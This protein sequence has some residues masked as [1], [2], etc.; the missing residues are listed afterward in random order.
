MMIGNVFAQN[1]NMTD[2]IFSIR[3]VEVVG[4]NL[5]KNE[6]GKLNVP[7]QY[8]PLS[9]TTVSAN[10]LDMRGIVNMQDAVKFLPNTRMRTTYGAYQQFEVRGFDFTPIMIDGVRDERTSITNSA[11]LPDLSSVESI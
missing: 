4:T 9:V 10:T 11:P 5:K 2:T 7:L 6:V 3:E 1:K 8:L